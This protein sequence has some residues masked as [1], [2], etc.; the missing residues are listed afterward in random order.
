LAPWPAAPAPP[1]HVPVTLLKTRSSS[2]SGLE[3]QHNKACDDVIAMQEHGISEL[4]EGQ[5]HGQ[6]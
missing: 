1:A 5:D 4:G 3:S 6:I 2:V